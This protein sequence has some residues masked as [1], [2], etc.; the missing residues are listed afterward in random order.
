MKAKT[1]VNKAALALPSTIQ[2][3]P[4]KEDI[5][6]AMVQRA[7]IKHSEEKQRLADLQQ[8]AKDKFQAALL[9]ELKAKPDSFSVKV[10]SWGAAAEIEYRL[11]V[12]PPHIEKLRAA[13]KSSPTLGSFDEVAAKRQIREGMST[14]GDRVKALL[15]NPD[16]VKKLDAALEAISTK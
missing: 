16:A 15:D 13:Y 8:A 1:P 10:S 7:F 5:I 9:A 11:E 2:P 4:R 12:C 14:S 6:S 3:P